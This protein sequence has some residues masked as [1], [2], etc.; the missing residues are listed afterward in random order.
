M[1]FGATIVTC[2]PNH[3]PVGITLPTEANELTGRRIRLQARAKLP[4]RKKLWKQVVRR[5]I[6]LQALNLH[7]NHPARR[8]L[9]QLVRETKTGDRT[10][11]EG[12]AAAL[13]FPAM[14]GELFRRDPDGEPPNRLLNYGYMVLRAA[15]ARAIVCAGLHPALSLQH[16]HRN[17]AFALADDFVE[18]LRPLVDDTVLRLMSYPGAGL[19]DRD[20]KKQLLS[21]LTYE[22]RVRE[23]TGPL[24][25][26][27]SR[28]MA[29]LVRCY[30]GTCDRL[31]LP[32][33]SLPPNEL[34]PME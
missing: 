3:F 22:I 7:P 29:S 34:P 6:A 32:S 30:E 16:Q 20:A 24:E 1:H 15:V 26:Q 11:C 8:Q 28:V 25:V 31:D 33:Y 12:R 17:N 19:V 18:P 5:K 2:G 13:Y 27:L 23:H 9:R 21:L 4:L 10:N 14:F